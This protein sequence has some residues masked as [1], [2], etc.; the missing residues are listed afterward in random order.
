MTP[1][2]DGTQPAPGP[3]SSAAFSVVM[4]DYDGAVSRDDFR[5]AVAALAAQTCDDFELL[6]YHD[7]PKAAAYDDDLADTPRPSR[8][9]TV[10][11]GARANDWGHSNRDR[12][13]REATGRWIVHTNAD[14]LFYPQAIERLKAA[15]TS[16]A[17]YFAARQRPLG[18]G[19]KSIAKRWDR[20]FGSNLQ[21]RALERVT[22]RQIVIYAVLMRGMIPAG[23]RFRR[24]PEAGQGQAM[25]MGGVPVRH[26]MIDAMQLVMRR[27]LWLAEGGW[28]DRSAESDGVL[29]TRFAAK[30]NVLVLPEILGEHW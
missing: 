12:G 24:V 30:Y 29:Y 19:T 9:R 18:W 28:S 2:P 14:N 3:A 22:E 10:V 27:D 13:I 6:V 11:T 1:A 25:V 21:G 15:V 23:N 16:D 5:R 7:G 26:G 17:P 4:V 8:M 20:W